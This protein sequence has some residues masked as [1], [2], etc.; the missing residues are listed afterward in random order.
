M[1][2]LHLN[3]LGLPQLEQNKQSLTIRR[4]KVLA[5]LAYLAMTNKPHSRDTLAT[6]FWPDLGQREARTALR[7]RL[8]ELRKLLGEGWLIL[9]GDQVRFQQDAEF[10][11]DTVQFEAN[12]AECAQHAHASDEV[13]DD[14]LPLLEEAI[15]LYRDDF[16]AGFTLSDAPDFDDWQFFQSESLR[17]Q[18]LS[19]LDR[20]GQGYEQKGQYERAILHLRRRL[21][22]DPTHEASHQRLMRLYAQTDQQA[23][24]LRQFDLCV[25]ALAE[26]LGLEPSL[27]T[28]RLY[29]AIKQGDLAFETKAELLIGG[30]YAIASL[31]DDLIGQGG[32]GR[33]Y[34]A[35]DRQTGGVVALKALRTERLNSNPDLLAR[36]KREGEALDQLQHPNIVR[37]IDTLEESDQAY[38]VMEYISGGSLRDFLDRSEIIPLERVLQ[39]GIELSDA[40]AQCHYR[41]IFHRDLKPSN[42]LLT[43]EGSACLSDFGVAHL[44]QAARLTQTG[45]ALGTLDYLAPEALKGEK[46]NA[47]ADIWSLGVLLFE[48]LAGQRPFSGQTSAQVLNEILSKAVPDLGSLRLNLP[49]ALLD[50]VK[51]MLNKVPSERIQSIRQVG[52]ILEDIYLG[53]QTPQASITPISVARQAHIN[54]H[55][56]PDIGYFYGRERE[57]SQLANWVLSKQCRLVAILGIGGQGKTALAVNFVRNLARQ[58]R[59]SFDRILWRSL[60]NAP[61]LDELLPI[62][63]RFLSEPAVISIPESLGERLTL[64][65]DYLNQ[66]QTLLILDNLESILDSENRAGRYRPGYEDYGQLIQYVGQHPHQSC[67]ILT[68]RER[69]QGFGRL[70]RSRQAVRSLKLQGLS[71]QASQE[72]LHQQGLLGETALERTLIARYSGHPLALMLVAETID[73]LYFGDVAAFLAEDMLIFDD[74]RDVLDQHFARLSPLEREIMTWLAI[75]REPVSVQDLGDNLLGPLNR[76]DYLEA[77]RALQRRSL[78]SKQDRGFSLQNVVT[79]YTTERFIEQICQELEQDILGALNRHA[80][81]K[82]QA[83]DYIRDSQ[84][85]LMLQPI[86]AHLLATL[87][88]ARLEK[89]LLAYLDRLR[90]EMPRGYA[91]GNILNW[92]LHMGA[93]LTKANFSH[94]AVWQAY[95]SGMQLPEVSFAEA[96]LAGSV[97]SDL[98]GTITAIAYS[99]DGQLLAAAMNDGQI[100]VWQAADGQPL[101]SW[102]GHIGMVMSV[103][104]SPDSKILASSSSD[105]TLR[106]WDAHTGQSL[107]TLLGHTKGIT[108]IC[109]SADGVTLVSGSADH[110][111][112]LW[113]V[114]TGHC[115]KILFGHTEVIQAVV[116]S[117]DGQILA[118][119]SNDTT[120]RLWDIRT[121]QCL[122]ILRGH[123]D[124]VH[125]LA[126]SPDNR[127]L[128]S[129]SYDLKVRLWDVHTGQCLKT[130]RGHSKGVTSVRFTPDGQTLA[131]GSNDRTVRLWDIYTGDCLKVLSGHTAG[132]SSICYS[133]DGQT[134]AT[135]SYQTGRL[136]DV[137]TG[138]VLK[139]LLGHANEV[140][141]LCFSADGKT[142]ASSHGDQRLRLWN[143]HTGQSRKSLRGH[144]KLIGAVALSPDDQI[145][146]SASNDQTVR[147]WDVHTGQCLKTL[148]GHKYGASSVCFSPDGKTLASGSVDQMV[149]LWDIATGRCLKTLAGHINGVSSICFSPD[150]ETL[151]SGSVD[152]TVRLWDISTGECFKILKGHRN[153]VMSVCFSPDGKMLASGS[154]DYTIRLWDVA[155]QSFMTLSGHTDWVQSL[156]YSPDGRFLAS[157]GND[158]TVRLWDVNIGHASKFCQ[159]IPIG[160]AQL[161]LVPMAIFWLA[162]VQMLP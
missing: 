93:D 74:I 123:T 149:R 147:L 79:E 85:R 36:F 21:S 51:A 113:D 107:K 106:L 102:E 61:P 67:V 30:R 103:A 138:Q 75:E 132:V 122:G 54:L 19:A 109:F 11:L 91:A 53:R 118:S 160:S 48:M 34:R 92:L 13:C 130:L 16:L 84:M 136:W 112:R 62:I 128:A 158:R 99:P 31:E 80:L 57:M 4:R 7:R 162:A 155:N 110:T 68:S 152:Q 33:V 60:L 65:L 27:E 39:I 96:D 129:A 15:A 59:P 73:E 105:Q 131:S 49:P 76:R 116:L 42:V 100:R 58:A 45:T 78:L 95:L 94:L 50:L 111:L 40:L 43:A 17:Q 71:S 37:L 89:N 137:Q 70:E 154:A 35:K 143:V 5:L 114:H 97:F 28:K 157:G 8:S 20:L 98:F 121:G 41:D 2:K 88:Q 64:L 6:L 144:T 72:L 134:L 3:L 1:P 120:A 139:T 150:G 142:L 156:V 69:P 86:T 133:P 29:E 148:A 135:G 32:M 119:G 159:G 9:E 161:P 44:G 90:S 47:Q 87:G 125:S 153:R 141:S 146:A 77:L 25:E 66:A 151:A 18:L 24:A 104:F 52:S 63:L 82:A 101:L 10:W 56:A 81:I 23:A 117:A 14:C 46:I 83:K 26:E 126:F 38:L 115:T 124:W 127:F 12:L 22:L 140:L 145:L 108:S 55:E